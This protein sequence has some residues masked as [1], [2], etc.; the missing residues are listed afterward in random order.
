MR[1][2]PVKRNGAFTPMDV[3]EIVPGDVVFLRGG[4]VVPADSVWLGE[5]PLEI[6]QAALT[7]ESLPVE[8]PREDADGGEIPPSHDVPPSPLPRPPP[9][10]RSGRLGRAS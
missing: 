1:K 10:R 4:N 3:T 7:G 6:D 5:E 9:A 8:V 2:L